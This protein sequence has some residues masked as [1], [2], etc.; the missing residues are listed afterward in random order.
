MSTLYLDRKELSLEAQ[1]G[2][3]VVRRG[4][5]HVRTVPLALVERV[6]VRGRVQLDTGV[7]ARLGE[8]GVGFVALTGRRTR[9]GAMLVGRPH[10]DVRLR[11]AQYQAYL[12]AEA[13]ARW[14]RRVVAGKIVGARRTL[15]GLLRERPDRRAPL[16]RALDRLDEALDR[17]RVERA[18]T[19]ESLMG[20]EGAAAA[21]YFRGLAAVFPAALG[22]HGR[23]RRPPRDPVNAVLSLAYT[24]LHAEAVQA[25]HAVGLDP[26]LGFLHEPSHGRESAAA[27]LVELFRGRVDR[28]AWGLFRDRVLRAEHFR[29]DGEAVLLGKAGRRKFYMRYERA[30][31]LWRRGM[32]RV[33]RATVRTLQREAR[34]P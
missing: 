13:R 12:D 20:I 1:G 23:N 11:L 29:E 32:R 34:R 18:L 17:L 26:M 14:A 10:G 16:R 28:W 30:A 19:V 21:A 25:V 3:L 24:L 33:L 8:A 22:F 5:V 9:F 4:G 15:Q 7:L 27:D 6:V 31:P 2:T